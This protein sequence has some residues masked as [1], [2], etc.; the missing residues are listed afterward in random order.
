MSFLLS[1]W[2]MLVVV[3]IAYGLDE[4]NSWC[5][6]QVVRNR[7]SCRSWW[8]SSYQACCPA[9]SFSKT[10]TLFPPPFSPHFGFSTP[11]APCPK[12]LP[13]IPILFHLFF[14]SPLPLP[15][16]NHGSNITVV[17]WTLREPKLMYKITKKVSYQ[18]I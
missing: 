9:P 13:T 11:F 3:M 2:S 4:F 17:F 12:K 7:E 18:S 10:L 1:S 16:Q 8:S 15:R 5:N 14:H 6:M